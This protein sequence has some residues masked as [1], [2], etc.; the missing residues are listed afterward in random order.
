MPKKPLNLLAKGEIDIVAG[1]KPD[2]R[3]AASMDFSA[4]Y[5]LHGD[6][7]MTPAR[8]Q[9]R[10]FNDLRGRIIGLIIGDEGSQERAQAW[11]DSIN[12]SVR[13]FRTTEA[14]ADNTLL[15]FNNAHAIYA[16]SLML[17]AHLQANPNC[18]A[19]DRALV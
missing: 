19:S 17:V 16:D 18:A 5:L 11:A 9:I 15:E 2:W 12:A 8:S 7:L 10:G 3:L 6:R 13:F 4:P 14:G 1:V